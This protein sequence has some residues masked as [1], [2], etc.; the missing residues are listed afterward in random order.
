MNIAFYFQ[1][2]GIYEIEIPDNA[3]RVVFQYGPESEPYTDIKIR[4]PEITEIV[5]KKDNNVRS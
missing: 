4:V 2:E 1:G 5:F 3:E